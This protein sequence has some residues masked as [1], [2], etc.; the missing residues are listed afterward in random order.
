M[1]LGA[2]RIW[3]YNKNLL[4]SSKGVR[5]IRVMLRGLQVWEGE[6]KKAS[7]DT[8]T[9]YTTTIL[10]PPSADGGEEGECASTL[11]A[12]LPPLPFKEGA[13][14]SGGPN[15]LD[16]GCLRAD[17]VGFMYV[18]MGIY[19]LERARAHTHTHIMCICMYVW[20]SE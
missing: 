8:A 14:D 6:I 9:D 2:M 16:S 19:I 11:L 15:A 7:G 10:M 20:V 1:T 4:E 13:A 17:P 5:Y 18:Y 3:N 12:K